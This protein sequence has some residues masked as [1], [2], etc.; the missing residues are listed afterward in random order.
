MPN[1]S[2][3]APDGSKWDSKYEF[4]VYTVLLGADNAIER[5]ERP[6]DTLA[7]TTSVPR[8]HCVECGSKQVAMRRTYTADF[9]VPSARAESGYCYIEAKGFFRGNKR[10]LFGALVQTLEAADLITVLQSDYKLKGLKRTPTIRSYI[11]SRGGRAVTFSELK[12]NPE[13]IHD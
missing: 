12:N 7:Y 3:T 2:F 9:R 11:E 8:A 5:T 10:V 4:A 13:I 1:F 6:R